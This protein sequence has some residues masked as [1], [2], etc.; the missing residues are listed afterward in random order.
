MLSISKIVELALTEDIFTGDISST[1]I[2]PA[3]RQGV[4]IIHMKEAGI[5]SGLELVRE[6]F[7]QVDDKL[8][9]ETK[10]RDGDRVEKGQTVARI[11]GSMVSILTGERLALNFLQRMSGIATKT[12][13]FV[14]LVEGHDVRIVDTRKTTPLLRLV[15][16]QAVR[17]GGGH[18]HR[19]GLYDAVMI[20]DNHI[21]A[22]GG[23]KMAVKLARA[24]I[25]HTMTIEV[26]TENLDQVQEALDAGADIIMLDNMAP[27]LM[28]RAV[29]LIAGRAIV[30]ASGGVNEANIMAIAATGIDIISLGALTHTIESLDISLDLNETKNRV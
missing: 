4:A 22:A 18:N 2:I 19:F 1:S 10:L 23:I 21:K 7:A 24:Q 12:R 6:V 25:P 13:Y 8:L 30:E 20:K 27:D 14:D 28:H 29:D 9:V 11:S 17:D 16:K 15:E 26:E 5:I 3:D